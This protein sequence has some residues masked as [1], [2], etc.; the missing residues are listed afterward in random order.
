MILKE[1]SLLKIYKRNINTK[2]LREALFDMATSSGS[3]KSEN[4]K[5]ELF[6]LDTIEA[7]T[8]EKPDNKVYEDI[9][10]NIQE[11]ENLLDVVREKLVLAKKNELNLNI[12]VEEVD[13]STD[14]KVIVNL[15][16]KIEFFKDKR[17]FSETKVN[18]NG[19]IINTINERNELI[20]NTKKN[21]YD[22]NWLQPFFDFM[23]NHSTLV[24]T[25][26]SGILLGGIL[27]LNSFGYIN[28]G[29]LLTRIG[30]NLFNTDT[31][32]P[33][34]SSTNVN[35]IHITIENTGNNTREVAS[36]FFRELGK[37]LLVVIDLY[38]EK[39]KDKRQ[40]YS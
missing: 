38:I 26:G 37:K 31:N 7:K 1:Y 3:N 24:F 8:I 40:K 15:N 13:V 6:K 18:D 29:S 30:I 14:K 11:S 17:I 4:I 9:L 36:G 33:Q 19:S 23:H 27:Y 22:I 25:V 21:I 32:L 39:L 2:V 35:P 28:I 34:S 5:E 20:S 10:Q 16:D 12:K